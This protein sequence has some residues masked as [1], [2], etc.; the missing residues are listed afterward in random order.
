MR[1]PGPQSPTSSTISSVHPVQVRIGNAYVEV[2]SYFRPVDTPDQIRARDDR[3]IPPLRLL[4]SAPSPS[5]HS[6]AAAAISAASGISTDSS[7]ATTGSIKYGQNRRSFREEEATWANVMG[8]ISRS[9]LIIGHVD[10][11]GIGR[12]CYED[13]YKMKLGWRNC[14]K[15]EEEEEDRAEDGYEGRRE[16]E[17]VRTECKDSSRDREGRSTPYLL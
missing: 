8:V 10:E 5:S 1:S 7:P 17:G 3:L 4:L 2:K 9:F 12:S 13:E 14:G 16:G 6:V 11:V 15:E